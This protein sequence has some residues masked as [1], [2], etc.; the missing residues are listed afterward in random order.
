MTASGCGNF[1]LG[2]DD[3]TT[4]ECSTVREGI[5][6]TLDGED[7]GVP[8]AELEAHVDG[9]A[10]CAAWR[11][12]AAGITRL[13]RLAPVGDPPV[14]PDRVYARVSAKPGVDRL[15]WALVLVAVCQFSVVV[16]QLLGSMPG[17]TGDAHGGH[18]QHETAAFNFAI[19]IGLLFVAARPYRARTQLPLLLSFA[20]VL[21]FL[22]T[23]DV[24]GGEVGWYRLSGHVPLLVGVLCT[25]LLGFGR[26]RAPEPGSHA[27]EDADTFTAT[28]DAEPAR[29]RRRTRSDR[30]QPPAAKRVA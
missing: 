14:V 9:C 17:L 11:E 19:A 10:D 16:S 8:V 28:A 3:W 15:R 23:V 7:P 30:H 13:A 24:L 2:A 21:L 29:A 26:W 22:S 18:L 6:A 27:R 4:M 25:I 1:C 12:A 20:G 5:S